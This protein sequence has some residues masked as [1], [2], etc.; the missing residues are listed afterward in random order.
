MQLGKKRKGRKPSKLTIHLSFRGHKLQ[1]ITCLWG[2][3]V[4]MASKILPSGKD[5]GERRLKKAHKPAGTS[6]SAYQ[7]GFS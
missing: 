1:T 7:T 2:S 6:I 4:F 3:H 5:G